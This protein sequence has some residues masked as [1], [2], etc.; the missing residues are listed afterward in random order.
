MPYYAF[1][2]NAIHVQNQ[3]GKIPDDDVITFQVVVNNVLRGQGTTTLT[4]IASGAVIPLVPPPSPTFTFTPLAPNPASAQNIDEDW[5]IGPIE[6]APGDGVTILYSGTNVS[7]QYASL[8]QQQQDSIETQLL[9]VYY[10][11]LIGE[12]VGGAAG[13]AIGAVFSKTSDILGKV[14]DVLSIFKDPVGE[15]LNVQSQGP[16][17]GIA[18]AGQSQLTGADLAKL[19]Y[20]PHS[21]YASL[22]NAL[23]YPMSVHL[24]DSD[25]HNTDTCGH[26]AETD[27]MLSILQVTEISVRYYLNR[28]FRNKNPETGLRQYSAAGKATN[29][30][31]LV[32]L[33]A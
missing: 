28:S 18:F 13:A 33:V 20:A 5:I 2:L 8:N 11:A 7:D 27:V 3:R 22:P 12:A 32:H 29:I 25:N 24:T 19:P 23:E 16:C 10:G 17:N 31:S 21:E 14:S 1:R 4:G 9:D 6:V 30:R 26:I 15:I